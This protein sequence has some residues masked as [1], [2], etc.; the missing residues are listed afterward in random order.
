MMDLY[1]EYWW[2]SYFHMADL[3]KRKLLHNLGSAREIFQATKGQLMEIGKLTD[4]Q[5]EAIITSRNSE[6][7]KRGVDEM[8]SKDIQLTTLGMADYPM[9]LRRVVDA[10]YGLF[11]YGDLSLV[12]NKTVGMVG[13]RRCTAYGRCMSEQFA[14]HLA[15]QGV[16]IVSGMARGVDGASHRG[17]LRGNGSTVAVLGGGVEFCYPRENYEIYQQLKSSGLILSQYCPGTQPQARFFPMRNRIISGLSDA[18]F[19]MEA[20]E[21][22]GSLITVDFALEQGKDIYAL[23]GRITDDMSGGCNHLIR[24]GAGI[25]LTPEQAWEEL[26]TIANSIYIEES[27]ME[28]IVRYYTP[29]KE[30]EIRETPG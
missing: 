15:K 23:P 18:V 17:A 5:A 1:T 29:V 27:E 11:Y 6:I 2:S 26:Q 16:V 30:V 20:R 22:S 24:Q 10:P 25:L 7:I 19:V 14:E 3:P 4:I 12:N 28:E 9:R 8:I 13:A 21:R